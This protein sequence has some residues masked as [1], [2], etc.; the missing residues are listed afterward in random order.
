MEKPKST[1]G[2]F[3][4]GF[5]ASTIIFIIIGIILYFVLKRYFQRL[6][7]KG[8]LVNSPEADRLRTRRKTPMKRTSPARVLRQTETITEEPEPIA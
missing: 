3:W 7:K 4:A 5:G 6:P 8:S 2:C 1:A